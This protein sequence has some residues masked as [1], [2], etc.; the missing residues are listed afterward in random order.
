LISGVPDRPRDRGSRRARAFAPALAALGIAAVA[1]GGCGGGGSE[2]SST[3]HATTSAG[4]SSTTS[5]Q[6]TTTT[7]TTSTDDGAGTG[8]G[9]ERHTIRDAVTAVLTSSDPAT[10]CGDVYVTPHYLSAAYGGKGGCVKAQSPKSVAQSVHI[11]DVYGI[12]T[13]APPLR[14]AAKVVPDGGVY[15]GEKLMVSLVREHGTW[16]VDALKSNAPV[17]P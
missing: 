7:T 11:A 5:A 2:G 4:A 8:H 15:D 12:D 1:F 6:S 14:A 17:G 9:G 16:R 3:S 10:A 13:M